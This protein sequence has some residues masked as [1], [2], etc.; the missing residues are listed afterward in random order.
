MC[1]PCVVQERA[2][3]LHSKTEWTQDLY[4]KKQPRGTGLYLEPD[5][6]WPMAEE[7]GLSLGPFGSDAQDI[8]LSQVGY[9]ILI[10]DHMIL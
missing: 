10:L 6:I 7:A 8:Q 4:W 2:R 9:L 5:D 1:S 3:Y